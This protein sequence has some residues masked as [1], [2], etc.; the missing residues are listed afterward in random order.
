MKSH[1]KVTTH[2]SKLKE[3]VLYVAAKCFKAPHFGS[4]KLNKILFYADMAAYLELGRPITGTKYCHYPKGPA[5]A[6]MKTLKRDLEHDQDAYEY[7]IPLP[8][9]LTQK[10]LL[11]IRQPVLDAFTP[12]EIAIVDGIVEEVWSMSAT[13]ISDLSHEFPGW[14]LAQEGEEIPYHTALIPRDTV[15]LSNDEMSWAQSIATRVTQISANI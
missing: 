12:A 6:C 14:K 3:L 8:C 2:E 13:Q 11:A 9:G 1:P 5:P 10:Q 15:E 4:V 7:R